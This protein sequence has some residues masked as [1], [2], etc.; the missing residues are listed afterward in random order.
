MISYSIT[1]Y[2]IIS[3]NIKLHKSTCFPGYY[4]NVVIVEVVIVELG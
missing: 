1:Y 4:V 3:Y 2:C